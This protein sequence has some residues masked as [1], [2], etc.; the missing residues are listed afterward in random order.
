LIFKGSQKNQYYLGT[1][2][3][4]APLNYQTWFEATL[5]P[6]QSKK[7]DESLRSD[8]PVLLV[9]K[10]RFCMANI[11]SL[12]ESDKFEIRGDLYSDSNLSPF[13]LG[14]KHAQLAIKSDKLKLQTNRVLNSLL[15]PQLVARE[16]FDFVD[17]KTVIPDILIE[18]RYNTDWNFIG[19]KIEGYRNNTCLLTKPAALKLAGVQKDVKKLGYS[20]LVF[21]CYR[22]QRAVNEFVVWAKDLKDTRMKIV[23]YPAVKKSKLVPEY[24]DD[25]S[26]HSRGS[27]VDLTLVK[28]GSKIT[29]DLQFKENMTD[30]RKV[31][32]IDKTGQVNMGTSYDCFSLQAHTNNK[33]VS[34][35]ALKNRNILKNAMTKHGFINYPKEWWHFMLKNEPY[36][37]QYFDLEVY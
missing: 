19:H 30:C 36:P 33:Q 28:L 18:A 26:G 25:K 5:T 13:V 15:D 8:R 1:L 34:S 3:E 7:V 4:Q 16:V 2:Y 22:P 20:L 21:D 27:V 14:E 9:T 35:E 24:I 10:N 37:K 12:L 17:I 23:F 32:G 31:D 11:R 29:K 6:A